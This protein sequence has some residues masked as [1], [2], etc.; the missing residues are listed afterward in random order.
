MNINFRV[1]EREF[2]AVK[3]VRDEEGNSQTRSVAE[4]AALDAAGPTDEEKKEAL[5]AEPTAKERAETVALVYALASDQVRKQ[6]DV[7]NRTDNEAREQM[8][9][10]RFTLRR[11]GSS[12]SSAVVEAKNPATRKALAKLDSAFDALSDGVGTLGGFVKISDAL[13]RCNKAVDA[14]E[15]MVRVELRSSLAVVDRSRGAP[16]QIESGRS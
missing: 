12:E 16:Q 11:S 5:A 9:N 14:L 1:V 8:R 13:K 6:F 2:N 3:A 4:K 15:E 10:I 7:V